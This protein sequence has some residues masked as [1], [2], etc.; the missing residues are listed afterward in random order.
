MILL[1]SDVTMTESQKSLK[2]LESEKQ[3]IG[4]KILMLEKEESI[5]KRQLF[6]SLELDST[7]IEVLK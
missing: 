7:T 1:F 3:E 6:G 4:S 5:L 2:E